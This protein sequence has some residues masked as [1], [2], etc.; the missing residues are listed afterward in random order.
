MKRNRFSEMVPPT[1]EDFHMSV[2]DALRR[3]PARQKRRASGAVRVAACAAV[4]LAVGAALAFALYM[5]PSPADRV[6]SPNRKMLTTPAPEAGNGEKLRL[7]IGDW[8]AD[9]SGVGL[10]W[11]IEGPSDET[12]LVCAGAELIPNDGR[13]FT[14]LMEVYCALLGQPVLGNGNGA[15]LKRSEWMSWT[16]SSETMPV[17]LTARIYVYRPKA[18]FIDDR[19]QRPENFEGVSK[20]LIS[21]YEDYVGA[22]P[23]DYY[24]RYDFQTPFGCDRMN[25]VKSAIGGDYF[26]DDASLNLADRMELERILLETLGYAELV[27]G[28]E[29]TIDMS[30]GSG[31]GATEIREI[32]PQKGLG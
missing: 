13:Y 2:V 7:K 8:R 31:S 4:L 6:A 23:I 18:E 10:D 25:S 30:A 19:D 3:L 28:Y 15:E 26:E 21:Q 9:A 17:Q 5:R 32:E 1:T 12:L 14:D 22:Q 29:V 11:S 24:G 20:W 27:K 16:D